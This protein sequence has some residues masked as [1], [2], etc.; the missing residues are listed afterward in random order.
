MWDTLG[1]TPGWQEECHLPTTFPGMGDTGVMLSLEQALIVPTTFVA[2]ASQPEG[3]H[4][5]PVVEG[6][7]MG[8]H[9]TK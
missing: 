3:A 4:D 6:L 8:P 5:D 9:L 7:S 2:R 1:G